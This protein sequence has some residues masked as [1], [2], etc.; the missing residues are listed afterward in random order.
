MERSQVFNLRVAET[1]RSSAALFAAFTRRSLQTVIFVRVHSIWNLFFLFFSLTTRTKSRFYQQ[2][3]S[4]CLS[5]LYYFLKVGG[6]V[7]PPQPLPQRV[8]EIT[9][10]WAKVTLLFYLDHALLS[11]KTS[12]HLR[13]KWP[14][15][16]N[17]I[18]EGTNMSPCQ[19][20]D[21][22]H[23]TIVQLPTI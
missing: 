8:P 19:H 13:S 23:Y 16:F 14:V 11:I 3:V 21:T 9:L 1:D 4:K 6:G 20:L 22:Q 5:I 15:Y 2:S 7:M 10:L 12:R 18:G 17:S